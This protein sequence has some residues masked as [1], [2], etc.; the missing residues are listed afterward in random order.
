MLRETWSYKKS[1][2]FEWK[3]HSD[4]IP[5]K[6]CFWSVSAPSVFVNSSRLQGS[7]KLVM[8]SS[9]NF[10]GAG[11]FGNM[12]CG[13]LGICSCVT[14]NPRAFRKKHLER[15]WLL[16][17]R[18]PGSWL[19][20]IL[21][22]DYIINILTNFIH[23]M[24]VGTLQSDSGLKRKHHLLL[25][26]EF[27]F[28]TTLLWCLFGWTAVS[29]MCFFNANNY[30]QVFLYSLMRASCAPLTGE[31]SHRIQLDGGS[32]LGSY[33]VTLARQQ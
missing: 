25:R 1:P 22:P 16:F 13:L 27:Y 15:I 28:Y 5:R 26:D 30:F 33:T 14:L 23:D 20:H 29:L 4:A 6:F 9:D 21:S 10:Q 12:S 31:L 11:F 19:F 2:S 18:F 17:Q 3:T 7:M 32:L 24:C 8:L